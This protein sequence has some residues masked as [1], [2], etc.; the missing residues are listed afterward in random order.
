MKFKS[1]FTSILVMATCLSQAQPTQPSP[2]LKKLDWTIGTWIG[3]VKW[4]MEGQAMDAPM[5]MKTEWDGPF[6]KSTSTMEMMGMKMLETSYTWWDAEKKKYFMTTY[7]NF[8]ATPRNETG[9]HEGDK[10]VWISDPW[11]TGMPGGPTVSRATLTRKSSTEVAFILEFK[12]GDK[13]AKVG[14]GTFK[15]Q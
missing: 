9:V 2:E 4:T 14:E 10:C 11:S 15:K 7:T 12:E 1:L 6:L 3:N 13:W 5:T 8:G